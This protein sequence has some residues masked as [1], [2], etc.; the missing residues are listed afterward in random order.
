MTDFFGLLQQPE[1]PYSGEATILRLPV[2]PSRASRELR[3]VLVTEALDCLRRLRHLKGLS[4][5][6]RPIQFRWLLNCPVV[7]ASTAYG[8]T[9]ID[10]ARG[11][12]KYCILV[13]GWNPNSQSG[14]TLS[15]ADFSVTR[16]TETS[17][18][19][20]LR[21]TAASSRCDQDSVLIASAAS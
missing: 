5:S 13:A 10:S 1:R 20:F 9:R 11:I 8:M 14:S 2:A 17:P 15:P 18:L 21:P 16:G 6:Q 7:S 19:G 4:Q 3:E 12:K